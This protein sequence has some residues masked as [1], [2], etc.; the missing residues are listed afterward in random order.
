MAAA[1]S[2]PVIAALAPIIAPPS[3]DM[4]EP[5][6]FILPEIIASDLENP[7]FTPIST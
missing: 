4:P 6:A 1:E 7:S 2:G 3:I 5:N